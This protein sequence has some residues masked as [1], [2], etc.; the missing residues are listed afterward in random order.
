MRR[1]RCLPR[2]N[3]GALTQTRTCWDRHHRTVSVTETGGHTVG[4]L[5]KLNVLPVISF[6]LLK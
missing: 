5:L 4:L 6:V 3:T 1:G 2:Q